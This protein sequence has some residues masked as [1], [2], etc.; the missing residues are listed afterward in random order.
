MPPLPL[1]V[2]STPA[3]GSF[4]R[5]SAVHVEWPPWHVADDIIKLCYSQSESEYS[6]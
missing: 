5:V 6:R 3:A 4:D 1:S 2:W